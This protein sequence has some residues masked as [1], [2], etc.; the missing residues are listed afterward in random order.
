MAQRFDNSVL[1]ETFQKC[2]ETS[3]LDIRVSPYLARTKRP[4]VRLV[5]LLGCIVLLPLMV[6]LT[7]LI[8]VTSKGPA[9]YSQTR[10]GQYGRK[11]KIYKFRSMR[12][13]AENGKAVWCGENDPRITRVGYYLRKLH[14]DEIPQLFN[15]ALGQ[16]DFVGPRP[17]RPE[18][19]TRLVEEITE[20]PVRMMVRPG[21]TG[22]AQVNLAPDQS[23]DCVRKKV[24][25]DAEYIEN[26]TFVMDLKI[27]LA[28]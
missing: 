28:T 25:V 17:E 11:F 7:I 5:A 3:I 26:A 12:I 23:V 22:L 24:V 21:I 6:V 13:D 2:N 4:L 1:E 19:V 9:F 18:F 8:R 16:M 20:Y 15:V 27:V 14:L 10:L